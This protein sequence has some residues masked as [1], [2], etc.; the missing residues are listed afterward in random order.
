MK[1]MKKMLAFVLAMAMTFAMTVTAFGAT[2]TTSITV[3]NLSTREQ[4]EVSIYKVAELDA[5]GNSWVISDWAKDY[6]NTEKAEAEFDWEGLEAASQKVKPDATQTVNSDVAVFENV[7]TGAYLVIA[8][9]TK[10][11]YSVMGAVTYKTQDVAPYIVAN[12]ATV[13]AKSESSKVEKDADDKFVAAE[14]N[15]NFT[16]TTTIPYN[17]ESFVVYDKM[18]NLV[19]DDKSVVVKVG[20]VVT[21]VKL[22]LDATTG[23]YFADLSKYVS[24]VGKT[25]VITYTAKVDGVNGY[26]NESWDNVTGEDGKDIVKGYTADITLTK[27][28]SDKSEVLTGAKFNVLKDNTV[29]SFVKVADGVYELSTAQDAVQEIEATNGTVQVKG[30]DEGT[31]SFV[32][33]IAPVGYSVNE[34][35]TVVT[36]KAD[37]SKNVSITDAEMLDTKL[38]SLPFTGGIGTTIFTV[39]GCLVMILAAGLFFSNRKKMAK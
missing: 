6:V 16:I 11:T 22:E 17:K 2:K 14:Q 12:D 32:E 1:T 30:L 37:E 25:V 33:T 13:I 21:D 28:N 4:T 8:N 29:L 10:V 5:N 26:V 35:P 38:S 39:V 3:T 9:G 24:E 34:N 19:L 31:Y 7:A 23:T 20:D 18:T 27:Y 15:V 36:V